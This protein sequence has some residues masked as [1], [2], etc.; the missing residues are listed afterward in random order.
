[1]LKN[2]QSMHILSDEV[3]PDT[4]LPGLD[5]SVGKGIDYFSKIHFKAL[6]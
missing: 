1:M 6:Q 2:I 4:A 5:G 3:H